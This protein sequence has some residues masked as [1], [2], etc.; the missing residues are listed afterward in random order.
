MKAGGRTGCPQDLTQ[1]PQ[2]PKAAVRG[3][4]RLRNER[5]SPPPEMPHQTASRH[6][7]KPS[8]NCIQTAGRRSMTSDSPRPSPRRDPHSAPRSVHMCPSTQARDPKADPGNRKPTP[9]PGLRTPR[10]VDRHWEE[11]KEELSAAH[12]RFRFLASALGGALHSRELGVASAGSR[13]F[14]LLPEVLILLPLSPPC[15]APAR[16]IEVVCND[17]LGKKVRVKLLMTPSGTLRS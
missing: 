16:M 1:A 11:R 8:T 4:V 7:E 5:S 13:R 6:S 14:E 2:S 3:S 9:G 15:V 12:F 17:R 10:G